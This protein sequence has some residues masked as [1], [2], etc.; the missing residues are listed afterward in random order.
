M[1][2]RAFLFSLF[3]YRFYIYNV[4]V[5]T[6]PTPIIL[7]IQR[8]LKPEMKRQG[9]IYTF[10]L[11]AFLSPQLKRLGFCFCFIFP[12][13]DCVE[14]MTKVTRETNHSIM[15]SGL[16]RRPLETDEKGKTQEEN[17][18]QKPILE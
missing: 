14:N 8:K 17:K 13:G 2:S 3:D 12:M 9:L 18:Q 16:K 7:A 1:P 6:V 11:L 5:T 10:L 4:E 15:I